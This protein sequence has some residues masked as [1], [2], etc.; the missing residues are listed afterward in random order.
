MNL[1]QLL[2]VF[3]GG[4]AGSVLRFL[5]SVAIVRYQFSSLPLATLIANL[6]AC[7]I[8]AIAV[9]VSFTSGLNE[10]VR[11]LLITGFC[12]GLSTLSTCSYETVTLI[13]GGNWQWAAGNIL[14]NL[15]VCLGILFLA[16]RK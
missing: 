2:L 4:G 10:Q 16:V 5:F 1:N 6:L 7:A 11:L 8:L 13:R 12:G 15:L 9:R 14:I 3:V